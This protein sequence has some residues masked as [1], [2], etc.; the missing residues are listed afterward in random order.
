MKLKRRQEV[1]FMTGVSGKDSFN[2]EETL[3]VR[4]SFIY[5]IKSQIISGKRKFFYS[6]LENITFMT[7][8]CDK[9]WFEII[10]YFT[11][12]HTQ[13]TVNWKFATRESHKIESLVHKMWE[14]MQISMYFD[15]YVWAMS[16]ISK[17]YVCLD[18]ILWLWCLPNS[19]RE[20]NVQ[21]TKRYFQSSSWI[22]PK[23]HI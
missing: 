3:N 2:N 15:F 4:W 11:L 12:W 16:T 23:E 9:I 21:T 10:I 6:K 1:D 17:S 22:T 13:I 18:L 14:N 8:E 7:C 19:R 5:K 20:T